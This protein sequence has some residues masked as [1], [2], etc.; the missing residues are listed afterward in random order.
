MAVRAT[1]VVA[2]GRSGSGGR[3]SVDPIVP[4]AHW[5]PGRVLADRFQRSPVAVTA[6]AALALLIPGAARADE[7]ADC[8]DANEK[9]IE[10][11]KE[12]ELLAARAT[13]ARCAAASCPEDL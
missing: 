11:R 5:A 3:G 2:A 4:A 10:Q 8:I 13:N 9:A 1:A 7:V 12:H 6:V